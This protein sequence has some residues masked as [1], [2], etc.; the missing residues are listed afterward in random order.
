MSEPDCGEIYEKYRKKVFGYAYSRLGNAMEAEDIVQT[1]FLKVCNSIATYDSAKA[2]LSTWIYTIT[3]NTVYSYLRKRRINSE[4][5]LA[6]NIAEQ[7]ESADEQ[8]EKQE[9]L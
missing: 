4:L 5:A 7:T 2:S 8:V 1:V 3:R 9:A 6:E